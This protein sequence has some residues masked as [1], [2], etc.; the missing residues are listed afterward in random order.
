MYIRRKGVRIRRK[1]RIVEVVVVNEKE[2]KG[3]GV[4]N[5]KKERK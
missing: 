4:E 5:R 3:R 2:K 1:T